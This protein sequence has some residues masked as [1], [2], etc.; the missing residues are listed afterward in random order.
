MFQCC[1]LAQNQYLN[2]RLCGLWTDGIIISCKA[3]M[4]K[5]VNAQVTHTFYE[6]WN[7]FVERSSGCR[8]TIWKRNIQ[9]PSAITN[10]TK[11]GGEACFHLISRYV[12]SSNSS[13]RFSKRVYKQRQ[14]CKS[15]SSESKRKILGS[16]VF[17]FVVDAGKTYQMKRI[18][19]E[20][21]PQISN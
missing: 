12:T 11:Y 17:T 14:L 18:Y 16:R 15:F 2:F 21:L 4:Y 5:Y 3:T 7:R 9:T 1:K 13:C 10:L 8:V 6:K 19:S 20:L